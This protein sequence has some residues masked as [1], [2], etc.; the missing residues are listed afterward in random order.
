MK[1]KNTIFIFSILVMAI[2]CVGCVCASEDNGTSGIDD[3]PAAMMQDDMSPISENES[4]V[5]ISDDQIA[6][7][8]TSEV[9]NT[10]ENVTQ[11]TNN[12]T[13]PDSTPAKVSKKTV[14]AFC[15]NAF[16]QKSNKYFTVKL[17]TLN[18][19]TNKL[20]YYKNVKITVKVN[21]NGKT[22][23]YNLKTNSKGVAKVLNVK[24]LKLGVHKL[25][26]KSN[27]SRY[28]INEKGMIG[29][30]SKKQKAITL[31]MNTRK[32]IKK[33]YIEVFYL[34]KNS[35]YPKGIYVDDYNGKDPQNVPSHFFIMKTKFFFKNKKT[36]KI[37]SKTVKTKDDK[38]Y[39]WVYPY[40]K[41]IK[42]YTPIKATIWYSKY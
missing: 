20:T 14:Y 32:K 13:T 22:K 38:I 3:A 19:K 31:K 12:T 41:P 9:E 36:G 40:H 35:Q 4:S 42:G 25:T 28:K 17:F 29:I 18:E 39:G 16:I 24:N 15:T 10:E 23:T 34:T 26:V 7:E 21:V 2:L 27:D 8:T 37:I 6:N 5:I 33:D 11:T 1:L 30:F